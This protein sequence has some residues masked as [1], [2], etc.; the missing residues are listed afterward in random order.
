MKK[1]NL[2]C[3]QL[4]KEGY[5][6]VDW[7]SLIAPDVSHNLNML[8]YPFQDGEFDLIEAHH[9]I[10]HLDRPFEVM[11]E[12]HRILAPGGVIHIKTPHFSRGFTHSEHAHGFDVTFPMYF[13]TSFLG[14]G[15]T[16]KE[17]TLEKLEF[18]LK[19]TPL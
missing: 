5:V 15:Y 11:K 6:N 4:M 17:L 3:G 13:N 2:G 18:K 8:P 9:V 14:S 16:G 19:P 7:D 10:E 12:L 1:L